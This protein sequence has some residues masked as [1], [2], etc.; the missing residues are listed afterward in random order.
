MPVS[1][2]EPRCKVVATHFAVSLFFATLL[3]IL[4]FRLWFPEG[5]HRLSGGWQLFWWIVC[6]DVVC[7]P[8]LTLLL[9]N[10]HKPKWERY[11]DLALVLLI[12]LAALG[13][14]LHS[15]AQV[16][17]LALVFEVDRFRVVSAADI[18]DA[19]ID[20]LPGWFRPWSATSIRTLGARPLTS[21]NE[22]WKSLEAALQGVEA[23]QRPWRWQ[24]YEKSRPEVLAHARPLAGLQAAHPEK[25]MLIDSAIEAALSETLA[26]EERDGQGL[27]WLPLVSRRSM[28]WVVLIDP[29]TL[30]I[31]AYVPLDGFK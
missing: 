31:R 14:G 27:L 10:P 1:L 19:D 23:G 28:E 7:G 12:Q 20:H 29:L 4:V 5:T 11:T 24:D 17:P 13:F 30:R 2:N 9:Y 21:E 22:K 16:R 25:R 3:A 6:V 26:R 18:V 8:L 15:L